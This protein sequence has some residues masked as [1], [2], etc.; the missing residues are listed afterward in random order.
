V[1]VRYGDNL[2]LLVTCDYT[3]TSGRFILCLRELRD[4]E[5]EDA[6]TRFPD[7]ALGYVTIKPCKEAEMEKELNRF[8]HP[9]F[10]GIKLHPGLHG[11]NVAHESYRPAMEY[12][13][14]NALP[15]LI[16]TWSHADV[17]DLAKLAAQYK[18]ASFIIA[19]MGGSPDVLNHAIDT[20][21]AH[22]NV[23]GDTALSYAPHRGIEYIVRRASAEKLLFGSDMP[24]YDPVFTLAR[25]VCADIHESEIEKI[26]GGNFKSICP[27][28]AE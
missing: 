11:V 19:H 6:I 7:R 12:A 23:F 13:N 2:L 25:V 9:G 18:F 26:A 24:F 17:S 4:D 8:R 28:A 15:V 3:N 21:I 22:D 5:A 27:K 1:D 14:A 16:H 10:I 20:L